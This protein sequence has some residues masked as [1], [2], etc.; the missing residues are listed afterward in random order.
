[1]PSSVD[2]S[3]ATPPR[4]RK[5]HRRYAPVVFALYMSSIMA[6]LMCCAIVGI[7][8]GLGAGYLQR[9]LHSYMFAMPVAFCC[10]M[11]VRPLVGRMVA[12]TVEL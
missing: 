2:L 12:A 7:N 4:S 10:V 5:L 6:L 3:A 11:L 1:M 8:T 9:V